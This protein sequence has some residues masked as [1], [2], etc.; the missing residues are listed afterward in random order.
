MFEGDIYKVIY[1]TRILI[2][3]TIHI[4]LPQVMPSH[5]EGHDGRPINRGLFLT[6]TVLKRTTIVTYR[7]DH[8]D[9][10][11]YATI[12]SEQGGYVLQGS[13]TKFFNCYHH[14]NLVEND[15]RYLHL[16]YFLYVLLFSTL[17][18]K[19][20]Y[21]LQSDFF[22]HLQLYFRCYASMANATRQARWIE[23]Q[24]KVSVK[25]QNAKLNLHWVNK[26]PVFTLFATKDIYGTIE[27]PVEILTSY[28]SGYQFPS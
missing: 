23:S 22:S 18:L 28:Q 11:A 21:P 14:A 12:Q 4:T 10:L 24:D 1:D 5:I 2:I 19:Y 26:L 3:Y 27:K 9:D 6:S 16:A 25:D 13:K 17:I 15:T 20:Y 7:G 8:I